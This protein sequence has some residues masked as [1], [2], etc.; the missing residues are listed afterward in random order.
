MLMLLLLMLQERRWCF[1]TLMVGVELQ[2]TT[3]RS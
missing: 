1:S 2:H 3:C